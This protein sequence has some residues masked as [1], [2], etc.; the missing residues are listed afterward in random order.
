MPTNPAETVCYPWPG[1]EIN[2][3]G[4]LTRNLLGFSLVLQDF[5][6]KKRYFK[7]NLLVMCSSCSLDS[8]PGLLPFQ[9]R[10]SR[11]RR[12]VALVVTDQGELVVYA[13]MSASQKVL[14]GFIE[15]NRAWILQKQEERRRAWA[16]IKPGQVYYQGQAFPLRLVPESPE[17]V[18]LLENACHLAGDPEEVWPRL[19]AWYLKEAEFLLVHR[20]KEFASR[21]NLTPP[22]VEVRDWRR[23]WGECRPGQ[24]LRFN[25]RL[26]LLPPEIL[27]YVVVHELVHLKVPG[28]PPSFW[29]EMGKYLPDYAARRRW[30]NRQ[31]G[32]FLAWRLDR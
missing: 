8:P 20:V 17:P 19:L 28:H 5:N 31:G 21:M 27:D 9:I 22:P 11:R 6:E 25:W 24:S 23:R 26:V 15:K 16:Q 2:L 30:L 7:E 32:P 1:D 3:G 4:F 14:E 12:R 10:W 29:R 13:P 18:R